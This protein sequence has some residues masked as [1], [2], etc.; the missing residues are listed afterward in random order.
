M[1]RKAGLTVQDLI[2]EL[3]KEEAEASD[4]AHQWPPEVLAK[5][6]E[7]GIKSYRGLWQNIAPAVEAALDALRGSTKEER[8]KW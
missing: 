4:D 3:S 6:A 2:A 7:A 5:V 1:P 8:K